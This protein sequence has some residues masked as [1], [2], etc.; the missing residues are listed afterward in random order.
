LPSGTKLAR[1]EESPGLR[2][3]R[4]GAKNYHVL[5]PWAPRTTVYLKVKPDTGKAGKSREENRDERQ[6]QQE[7][8][9]RHSRERWTGT[10]G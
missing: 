2:T 1:N 6:A 9:D 4:M 5:P 8:M 7:D 3:I 10:A